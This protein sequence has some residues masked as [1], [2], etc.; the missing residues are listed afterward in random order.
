MENFY[1]ILGINSS[2]TPEEIRR[3]Y[4]IL[5]R[6]YHPDLNPG[7]SSTERFKLISQAYETLSDPEKRRNYDI[8]FDGGSSFRG[9]AADRAY[10]RAARAAAQAE[11]R[12]RYQ[13]FQAAQSARAAASQKSPKAPPKTSP[14]KSSTG[15]LNIASAA[16][17]GLGLGLGGKRR[18]EPAR[19]N[20]L[21]VVEV[22]VT[23]RDAVLGVKKAI[24]IPE[25]TGPRKISVKIPPGSRNGTVVHLR[26]TQD[27]PEELVL[28][29]RVAAHPFLSLQPKGLIIDTPITV[30]EAICG[31]S[32]SVPT[33]DDPI[34]IK[35]P[36]GSQ[37]GTE[38]R[39][40]GRGISQKDGS[41]GDLFYRLLIK[42]PEATSAA[43]IMDKAKELE[44]YYGEPVR[45]P[46]S[47]G[48]LD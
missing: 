27:P 6:R 35:V 25:A 2:A 8:E 44:L 12:R 29:V 31:A 42:V 4:R 15:L 22:S 14:Q 13:E 34:S 20:R 32:I 37:S 28:I 38:L 5:A 17:R 46:I 45:R 33:L 30:S 11:T 39:V 24:E 16:I 19:S 7:E 40:R 43:G 9:G 47:L 23:L 41:K 21:S 26:A 48:L 3:A 36:P 1:K 18:S 10:R